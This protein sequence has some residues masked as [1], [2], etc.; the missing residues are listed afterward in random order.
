M[1]VDPTDNFANTFRAAATPSEILPL[2]RCEVG[3]IGF[4]CPNDGVALVKRYY[5]DDCMDV[6]KRDVHVAANGDES[7]HIDE[8]IGMKS[9]L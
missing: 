7:K 5:G 2:Q 3:G 9:E 4:P 6:V 1:L 8:S